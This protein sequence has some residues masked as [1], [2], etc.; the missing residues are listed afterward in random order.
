MQL[1]HNDESGIIQLYVG[2]LL[3]ERFGPDIE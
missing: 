2:E 1:A 3:A